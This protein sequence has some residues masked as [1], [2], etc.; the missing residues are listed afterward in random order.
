MYF[1]A[2]GVPTAIVISSA[3]VAAARLQAAALGAPAYSMVVVPHPVQ[4]LTP[5]ELY[6]LADKIF[7]EVVRRVTSAG[8]GLS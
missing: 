7:D 5:E 6:R 3:F 1:E 8:D 4:P 2:H